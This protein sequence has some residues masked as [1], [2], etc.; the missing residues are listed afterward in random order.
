M[1]MFM[2]FYGLHHSRGDLQVSLVAIEDYREA[3]AHVTEVETANQR[4]A[5]MLPTQ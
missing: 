5:A 2:L 1:S 4:D 3:R